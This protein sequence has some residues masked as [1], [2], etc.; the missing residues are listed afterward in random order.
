VYWTSAPDPVEMQR[1]GRRSGHPSEPAAELMDVEMDA[2][3]TSDV[4]CVR[5]SVV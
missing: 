2:S 1:N 5:L 4:V 3:L